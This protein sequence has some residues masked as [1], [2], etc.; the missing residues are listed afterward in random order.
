MAAGFERIVS[1]NNGSGY[2]AMQTNRFVWDGNVLLAVLNHTNGLELAFLRGLD[3]SGTMQGAGGVG[4]LLAIWDGPQPS[5][6]QPSTHFACYD[7]NGNVAALVSG[8]GGVETARYEYGPFGEPL[9]VTGP[10]AKVNPLRFSTQ[11]ADDVT[12][13]VRYLYRDYTPST[14]RWKSRD[15]MG[16]KSGPNEYAFVENGGIDRTDVYGLDDLD[17]WGKRHDLLTAAI[18]RLISE[19]AA[20]TFL[21]VEGWPEPL[22]KLRS[23]IPSIPYVTHS[24][25]FDQPSY[26]HGQLNM[27]TDGQ[28]LT[29]A[30]ELVHAYNDLKRTGFT[31]HRDDEGMAYAL[32]AVYEIRSGFSR[33]ESL[34]T[35]GNC[36]SN[37]E[38]IISAWQT[39]WK[40]NDGPRVFT[41]SYCKSW[42]RGRADEPLTSTDF[43]RI[44]TVLAAKVNCGKLADAAQVLAGKNGCG[45]M[46]FTCEKDPDGPYSIPAGVVL[47][48]VFR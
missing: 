10:M 26:L 42:L 1:T 47:D 9:R 45:C 18:D 8:E 3:L 11:Y 7:G 14:G 39:V 44:Q 46:F 48:P 43:T 36:D 4:G 20:H 22:A 35:G 29:S 37:R 41:V 21:G 31:K 16:E 23:I 6:S 13:D 34:L 19:A 5:T 32:D 38:K 27:G 33:L 40:F 28:D 12:G 24:V 17:D 30:H 25:D 15:P 2:I